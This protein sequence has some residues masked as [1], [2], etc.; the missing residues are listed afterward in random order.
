MDSFSS[1][2]L[3]ED[4]GRFHR[5]HGRLP[6][7]EKHR[8]DFHKPYV[9]HHDDENTCDAHGEKSQNQCSFMAEFTCDES[10]EKGEDPDG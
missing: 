3:I 5:Q 8:N 10:D 6:E 7:S 1:I 9:L 4:E 2:S